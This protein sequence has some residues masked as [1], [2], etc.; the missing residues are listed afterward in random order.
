MKGTPSVRAQRPSEVLPSSAPS[1]IGADDSVL[2][3][4]SCARHFA[5]R[6]TSRVDAVTVLTVNPE[7][8]ALVSPLVPVWGASSSRNPYNGARPFGIWAPSL[9]R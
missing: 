8:K 3:I 1:T 2:S 9:L 4:L 5:M 7:L 6:A